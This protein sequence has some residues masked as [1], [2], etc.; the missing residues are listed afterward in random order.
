MEVLKATQAELV[1]ENA[2]LRSAE[3]T[4]SYDYQVGGSLP[5]DAPTYIVWQADRNLYKALKLG[6]F[7]YILNSWQVGKSSLRVQIMKRLKAEGF[8]CAAINLSE[9]GNRQT[10]PDQ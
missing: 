5:M 3:Q 6:E 2:L 10:T 1:I 4:L 8:A 7:C 9:I